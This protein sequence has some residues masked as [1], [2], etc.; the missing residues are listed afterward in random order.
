MGATLDVAIGVTFV[1]LLLSLVCTAVAEAVEHVFKYRAHYLRLGV[2]KLLLDGSPRLRDAL[3]EHP[4]IKSLYVPSLL[5]GL[6]RTTG[7]SY[8][9]SRSFAL[10]L[11]DLVS[12][13]GGPP[14]APARTVGDLMASLDADASTL[15]RNLVAALR[16]LA[17]DAGDDLAKFKLGIEQWF[18]SSMDRVAGWYK[19]RAQFVSLILGLAVSVG[20]NA[21]TLD[22]VRTLSSDSVVRASLV[23]AAEKALPAGGDTAEAAAGGGDAVSEARRQVRKAVEDLGGLGVP[24]GWRWIETTPGPQP[25]IDLVRERAWPGWPWSGR[26]REQVAAH[27]LGWLLTGLA[28]SLGAPF[29]FDLLSRFM[30]VRTSIR[31]RG[32]AEGA[33]AGRSGTPGPTTL[34]IEVAPPAGA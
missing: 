19:R 33:G 25:A 24:I 28:L 8:I 14:A 34:R 6:V 5:P 11:L 18:D 21:D 17:A 16:T 27:L 29:W 12:R 4:L 2:E 1:F 3:Y 22:I 32:A 7:P 10:A 13:H 20:L 23:A 26:W 9:P 31:P 15:P 30:V